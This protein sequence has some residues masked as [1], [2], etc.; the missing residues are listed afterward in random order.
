MNRI[1]TAR[2]AGLGIF[3]SE[4]GTTT[5]DGKGDTVFEEETKKWIA[6]MKERNISWANWSFGSRDETSAA[7]KPETMGGAYTE[8]C[9]TKSGRFVFT[10]FE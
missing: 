10:L 4:W 6:F 9:L 5:A 8:E 1:D 3:M 2:N 7:L